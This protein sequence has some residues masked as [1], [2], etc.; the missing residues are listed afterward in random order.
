MANEVREKHL[1]AG[2]DER[3]RGFTRIVSVEQQAETFRASLQYETLLAVSADADS[4]AAALADLVRKLHGRGYT[5]LRSRLTFAGGTYLGTQEQW[6]EYAD[7]LLLSSQIG[8]PGKGQ[9]TSELRVS[10]SVELP[11][12]VGERGGWTVCVRAHRKKR[13]VLKRRA[14]GL[15]L[16]LNGDYARETTRALVQP[17]Q[18]VLL[19][20]LIRHESFSP[21]SL[22]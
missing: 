1:L 9:S 3:T 11:D 7:P 10:P 13:F 15:G 6:V 12:Q 17:G 22:R 2:L 16:L 5:Q 18:Q 8:A 14:E 20:H 21:S 4:P 19:T